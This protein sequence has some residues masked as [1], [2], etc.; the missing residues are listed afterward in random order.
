MNR[1][2]THPTP[3]GV[4]PYSAVV[5]K[6]VEHHRDHHKLSQ[7]DIA[8]KLSLSQSAY[9]RLESGQSTFSLP[10]LRTV[11]ALLQT[12][13]AEIIAEADRYAQQLE[14]R[15]VRVPNE[16]EVNKAGLLIG[17]GILLALL[18]KG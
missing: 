2:A 3:Q 1:K 7:H 9:S 12:T 16:K 6:V 13:S 10:Q 15:G 17:L 14:A 4:I 8:L 5:G 18:T 11:A